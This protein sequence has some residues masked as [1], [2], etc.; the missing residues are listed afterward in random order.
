[1]P[2]YDFRG[3][4]D[5]SGNINGT[6]T[7]RSDVDCGAIGIVGMCVIYILSLIGGISMVATVAKESPVCIVPAILGFIIML[8]PLI[9]VTNTGD[10]F[11]N[12]LIQFYKWSDL[13]LGLILVMYWIAYLSQA[14]SIVALSAIAVGLMYL[15]GISGYKVYERTG[16]V[17]CVIST[18]IPVIVYLICNA[19]VSDIEIGYLA[20][21][22][23]ISIFLSML[24]REIA[25]IYEL[26]HNYESNKIAKPIIKI[27]LYVSIV[28]SI[29]LFAVYVGDNKS[30]KIQTAKDYISENR[31][32]EARE[33]LQD[34]K[35]EEAKELYASIRYKDIKVGEIIYN[36]SYKSY[37]ARSISKNGIAFVCLDVV[38]GKALLISLDVIG[39][40]EQFNAILDEEYYTGEYLFDVDKIIPTT[41]GEEQ[42]KFFMLSKE[43]FDTYIQNDAVDDYLKSAKASDIAQK[44]KKSVDEDTYKWT[45]PYID[46]WLLN[47]FSKEEGSWFSSVGTINS[48]TGEYKKMSNYD[49][50]AGIRPCYYVDVN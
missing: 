29:F 4:I 10:F 15:M 39:L 18:A 23:T 25:D 33:L 49:V 7:P 20:L 50:Y 28:I 34:V 48:S 26:T 31:F 40:S 8:I 46:I 13:L 37:D 16:I 41:I 24:I 38:D 22:P 5:S 32:S 43:Q 3:T 11:S 45:E 19:V 9:T 47:D 21:I 36:G 35:S 44:Q 6:L 17:G 2:E 27:A 14:V 42:G 1:M 30:D 12:L